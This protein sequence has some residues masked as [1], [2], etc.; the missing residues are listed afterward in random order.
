M[1]RVLRTYVSQAIQIFYK[2]VAGDADISHESGSVAGDEDKIK[3]SQGMPCHG[4]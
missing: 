2:G 4:H 3:V 1:S